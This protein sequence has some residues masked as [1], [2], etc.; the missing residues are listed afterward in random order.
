MRAL[1]RAVLAAECAEWTLSKVIRLLTA[2]DAL[3]D[4]G[5]EKEWLTAYRRQLADQAASAREV[6]ATCESRRRQFEEALAACGDP[7]TEQILRLKFQR[8]FT[9]QGVA[10]R[11]GGGNTEDSVRKRAERYLKDL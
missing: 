10:L 6:L 5:A 9:W 1:S 3:Q 8:G 4:M 11:I 2:A 7:L